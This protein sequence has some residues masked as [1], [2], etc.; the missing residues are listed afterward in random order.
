MAIGIIGAMESEVAG[1]IAQL[2][3][4]IL[5]EAARLKFYQGRLVN[6]PVVVVQSGIGKVN[7]AM[8]AQI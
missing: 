6:H 5:T 3:H 8:C 1:L 7:A 4:S 2:S